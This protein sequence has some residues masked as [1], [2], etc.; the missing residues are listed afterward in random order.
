MATERPSTSHD[1]RASSAIPGLPGVAEA[2]GARPSTVPSAM[3][4][5]SGT[6]R[7]EMGM[8]ATSTATRTRRGDRSTVRWMAKDVEKMSVLESERDTDYD[9][10]IDADDPNRYVPAFV[11]PRT[12]EPFKAFC[13]STRE[14]T[15]IICPVHSHKG[16]KSELLRDFCCREKRRLVPKREQVDT[17]LRELHRLREQVH[18]RAAKLHTEVDRSVTDIVRRLNKRR[19]A[20]HEDIRARS[21]QTLS[22]IENELSTRKDEM[23]TLRSAKLTL[24][25]LS[26]GRGVAPDG[27]IGGV[28]RGEHTYDEFLD[29]GDPPLKPAPIMRENLNLS[30]AL[31]VRD[32][33]LHFDWTPETRNLQPLVYPP[34]GF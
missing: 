17:L 22:T 7:R 14:L 15:S 23:Q 29:I 30:L 33:V 8:R 11:C 28:L 32:E 12:G 34:K 19:N 31:Q 21:A 25:L 20:L 1:Q 13:H 9:D 10:E 2:F 27:D 16:L 3:P 18:E 4:N 24:S 6:P 26:S 5:V